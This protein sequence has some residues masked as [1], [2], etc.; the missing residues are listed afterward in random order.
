MNILR[1]LS[2]EL[3]Y[4]TFAAMAFNVL[5]VANAAEVS[6]R[7]V[8]VQIKQEIQN[9]S[10]QFEMVKRDQLNYKIEKDLLKETYASNMQTVNVV[11]A[12][13]LG[14]ISVFGYLGIR[15]IKEIRT[16]YSSELEKLKEVK[17][18]LQDEI[19]SLRS[20]QKEFDSLMMDVNKTNEEQNKRL[21]TMELIEKIANIINGRQ[22][23]WALQY[24]SIALELDP[25]N[26]IL[27]AQKSICCS[28]LGDFIQAIRYAEEVLEVEP[29][30][31]GV[32]FNLL[33]YFAL[34]GNA[35]DFDRVYQAY[36]SKVDAEMNGALI[37]YLLC[38]LNV[39]TSQVSMAKD[40]LSKFAS[41]QDQA[42]TKN[43]LG[44]WDFHEALLRYNDLIDGEQKNLLGVV[45]G[46][47]QGTLNPG[48]CK[49]AVSKIG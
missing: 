30:N 25:K 10:H 43:Y 49:E 17:T 36:K 47:F 33:E 28:K 45:L 42:L 32:A 44:N 20:K 11:I 6:E 23:Q 39:M 46:L 14:V 15:S 1:L 22:W 19:D 38:V 41:K 4:L 31:T 48:Q 24:I 29:E 16:D 26:P 13:V 2:K 35:L 34:T 5:N 37:A 40:D 27:L 8:V 7:P 12:I 9:L 18:K 3:F 21:R